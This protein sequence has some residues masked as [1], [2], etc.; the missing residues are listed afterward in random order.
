MIC[1]HRQ[2]LR[3]IRSD[4][5]ESVMHYNCDLHSAGCVDAVTHFDHFSEIRIAHCNNG[6]PVE[7]CAKWIDPP[8]TPCNPTS[9]HLVITVATGPSWGCVLELT[10]PYMQAY[11]K[12]INADFYTITNTTQNWP[13]FEKL[14]I[15]QIA[16]RYER[17]LFLDADTIIKPTC[18]NLF[19]LVPVRTVGMHDDLPHIQ[20][21]FVKS[22]SYSYTQLAMETG[23]SLDLPN[24]WGNTG[25]V[26]FDGVDSDIWTPPT[27]GIPG[28]HCDEQFFVNHNCLAKQRPITLLSSD[29]NHQY[30]FTD[31]WEPEKLNAAQIVHFSGRPPNRLEMIRDFVST[32]E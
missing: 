10:V 30:W 22:A 17:V 1:P 6:N 7:Y 15:R 8:E 31:F 29:Y 13:M 20:P 23:I 12:K 4:G 24:V 27:M 21:Q 25:V 9:N 19:D 3:S 5:S 11:A 18:P 26:V 28:G 2:G 16:A 14:R 32:L